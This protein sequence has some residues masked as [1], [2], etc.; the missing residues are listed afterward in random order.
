MSDG[1]TAVKHK[2][3]PLSHQDLYYLNM[4]EQ[5][6]DDITLDFFYKPHTIT[7]IPIILL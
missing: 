6:V 3:V 1:V 4:N 5:K 7:L 2:K